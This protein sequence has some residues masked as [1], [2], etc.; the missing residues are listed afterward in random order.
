MKFQKLFY[1]DEVSGDIDE[2]ISKRVEFFFHYWQF[3]FTS[4]KVNFDEYYLKSHRTVIDKVSLQIDGN[5]NKAKK[6]INFF[7]IDGEQ[8]ENKNII[9]KKIAGTKERRAISKLKKLSKTSNNQWC[10]LKPKKFHTQLNKIK[11]WLENDYSSLITE[12][13]IN[14]LE[15]K[16]P[17]DDKDIIDIKKLTNYFIV[18]LF[19]KGFNNKSIK[20]LNT[21]LFNPKYFPFEKLMSDFNTKEEYETY[22]SSEWDSMTLKKQIEGIL[23]L[24]NR[25]TK[26]RYIIFRIYDINLRTTPITFFDVEFY[27]PNP[28]FNPKINHRLPIRLFEETF[29]HEP[30]RYEDSS[31]CNAC[32]NIEGVQ[33]EQMYQKAFKKVKTAL[34]ILNRELGTEG[35]VYIK[36]AFITNGYFNQIWGSTD[37]L[38]RGLKAIDVTNEEQNNR[39]LYLQKLS[40]NNLEDTKVINL[41]SSISEVL[42]DKELYNPEKIWMILEATFGDKKEIEKLFKDIY[43]LYLHD[44]F[45]FIWKQ[46]FNYTLN[47]K[48]SLF[49]HP[50]LDYELTAKDVKKIKLEI[51]NNNHNLNKFLDN[52]LT[53]YSIITTPFIKDFVEYIDSYKNDRSNFYKK[54][55]NYIAYNIAELYSQRNLTLHSNMSDELFLLKQKEMKSMINIV[56]EIYVFI[57]LKSQKKRSIKQ[58]KSK[59]STK[60]TLL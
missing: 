42:M 25:N 60:A 20:D 13:I 24:I 55:D 51:K 57:Y 29:T 28:G 27:N 10:N 40:F 53:L 54:L 1:L 48:I 33:D 22:I 30:A 34:T 38:N 23:N 17:I 58:T 9:L 32:I 4:Q 36:N 37:A 21:A 39:L 50:E 47:P 12:S 7:F 8:F 43:R 19:N 41:I 35:K 59:I 6:N 16:N 56:L 11:V 52:I 5:F 15:K 14:L 44:N 26:S 49:T 45:A 3:L 18:E 46:F 31:Q 2:N